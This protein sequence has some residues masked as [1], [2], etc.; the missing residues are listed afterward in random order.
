MLE[1]LGLVLLIN[2]NMKNATKR[3]RKPGLFA[4]LTIILW[5]VFELLGALV[6]GMTLR[7]VSIVTYLIVIAFALVGGLI[8]F[9]I[10]K[11][12]KEG[13]YNPSAAQAQLLDQIAQQAKPLEIPAKILLVRDR[14]MVSAALPI[15]FSLNGKTL[16]QLN[17]RASFAFEAAQSRNILIAVDQYGSQ[18]KPLVFD[19]E[20]GAQAEIH[21][22]PF[23]F[24]QAAAKGI[25]SAE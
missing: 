23:K 10:A 12:C 21:F 16:C 19:I 6:V 22:R 4:A 18:S 24:D 2:L 25:T 15:T 14:S 11:N 13:D 9:L 7:E 5:V 3:G 17:N 8:S 20:S 1:V